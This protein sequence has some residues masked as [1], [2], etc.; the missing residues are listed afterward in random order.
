MP[1]SQTP[2]L[3]KFREYPRT[4]STDPAKNILFDVMDDLYDRGVLNDIDDDVMEEL[5]QTNLEHIKKSM[6]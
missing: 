1:D 6:S 4:L 3:D 2:L 5:F